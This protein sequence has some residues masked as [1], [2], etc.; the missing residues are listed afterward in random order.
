MEGR[1]RGVGQGRVFAEACGEGVVGVD[2]GAELAAESDVVGRAT[3]AFEPGFDFGDLDIVDGGPVPDFDAKL[4]DVEGGFAAPVG[5][6]EA[7]ESEDGRFVE[8]FGFR[9][10]DG[11]FYAGLIAKSDE[12]FA[13]GRH[14]GMVAHVFAFCSPT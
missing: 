10:V 7:L 5:V 13:G 9:D 2:E 11:V 4:A 1:Y 8:G 14:G 12:A 3:R 6:A